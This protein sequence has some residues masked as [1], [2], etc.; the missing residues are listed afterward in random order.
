MTMT[1]RYW[2]RPKQYGYGATPVTWE[3]WVFTL[4]VAVLIA[5]MSSYVFGRG[6]PPG[7]MAIVVWAVVVV[8]IIAGTVRV[9][10]TKTEGA[11]RWRWG[12]PE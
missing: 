2:F 12:D 8:A 4:V 10:R 5:A 9:A 6:A 11:W 3:G 1:A 7:A